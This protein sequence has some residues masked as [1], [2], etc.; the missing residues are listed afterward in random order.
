MTVAIHQTEAVADEPLELLRGMLAEQFAL[1]T[2]RLA[3][4]AVS[5]GLPDGGEDQHTL[6]VL[7]TASRQA[8][9]DAARALQ[10]MAEGTYGLCENC[11]QSIP[12]GRL[13]AMPDA[14]YCTRCRPHIGRRRWT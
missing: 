2:A 6:D 11:H 5:E 1:H 13:R 8:I 7:A 10:R 3:E 9:R 4:L 14:R 12:L